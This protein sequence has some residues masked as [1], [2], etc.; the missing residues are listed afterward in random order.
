MMVCMVWTFFVFTKAISVCTSSL[1]KSLW[2]RLFCHLFY[3]SKS[4]RHLSSNRPGKFVRLE[5][6]GQ[7]HVS[8]GVCG[9]G[10]GR[11]YTFPGWWKPSYNNENPVLIVKSH[12]F[13][14][15]LKFV[16]QS[17]TILSHDGGGGGQLRSMGTKYVNPDLTTIHSCLQYWYTST[18]IKFC[19]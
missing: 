9:V 12:L 3:I 1:P 8:S 11:D 16:Y 19:L 6:Q 10:G 5:R 18:K 7:W 2:D 14:G 13:M 4:H 17:I 15:C